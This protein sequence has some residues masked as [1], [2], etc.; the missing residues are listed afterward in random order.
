[1]ENGVLFVC[2][3]CWWKVPAPDR[4]S[5]RAMWVRRQ[6]KISLVTCTG[7]RPEAFALCERWMHRQSIEYAQWLVLCDGRQPTRGT[8][9]RQVLHYWPD[10]RGPGSMPNKLARMIERKLVW[11]DVVLFIEDDDWYA[12]DYLEAMIGALYFHGMVGEGKAVY[13][14]VGWRTWHV[15][16]NMEHASLCSTAIQA[17]MLKALAWLLKERPADVFVDDVLWKRKFTDAIVLDPEESGRRCVGI[18]GMP[19]RL[20]YG[21]GHTQRVGTFPDPKLEHLRQL[22]G[23]DVQ[24]Y[25]PFYN[26]NWHP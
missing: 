15:H 26:P 19:G 25:A 3:T 7:D 23:A 8:M 16:S 1:M 6:A 2:G 10:L 4:V 22:I 21:T 13:Y 17:S 24:H 9:P 20:G 18:K 14:H 11:G 12:R 5:L